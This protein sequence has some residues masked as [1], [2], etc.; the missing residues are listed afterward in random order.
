MNAQ[1]KPTEALESLED[2][3]ERLFKACNLLEILKGIDANE[4]T[5]NM[6]HEDIIKII[7]DSL[8][9]TFDPIEIIN[10]ALKVD[11][12][13]KSKKLSQESVDLALQIQ[14]MDEDARNFAIASIHAIKRR[15][16]R[17]DDLK[18]QDY[19]DSIASC[20]RT[21]EE[22]K[23]VA[24]LLTVAAGNDDPLFFDETLEHIGCLI[25][26]KVT[27]TMDEINQK[28]VVSEEGQ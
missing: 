22:I 8:Q 27:A 25:T 24:D 3:R 23:A 2:V 13:G 18:P 16:T 20:I 4:D 11:D 15:E 9:G 26:D 7:D 17:G 28:P 21:L 19:E 12:N 5:F 1:T 14:S 6:G 10:K